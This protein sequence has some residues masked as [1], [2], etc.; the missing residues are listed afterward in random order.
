MKILHVADI[1]LGR[2]RLSGKLPDSDFAEALG[3]IVNIAISENVDV[4]LI[5]GDLFDS[6]QIH[7]PA[8]KQAITCLSPLKGEGIPVLAIEGN[9]DRVSLQ[10]ASPTWMRYL[11]DEG[12]LHLLTTPFAPDGPVLL[13]WD[14]GRRQG[15]WI[16]IN[17]IRFIGA[18]YLGAGTPKRVRAILEGIESGGPTVLV[19][20]AGPDYFVG[21]GG[22]FSKEDLSFIKDKVS[23]LALGHI[24][25]P[26]IHENWACNP[27]SPEN[28][29][30]QEDGKSYAL[31]NRGYA[32]VVICETARRPPESMEIRSNPRRPV[33][34][35]TL[36]CSPFGNKLKGG[37][38]A[39]RDS[40]VRALRQRG[41][42]P[43]SAVLLCLSGT[44]NI[45]RIG[46][47]PD[48]L[49]SE[50]EE[51]LGVKAVEVSTEKLQL[52]QGR[53]SS[54]LSGPELV[55]REELERSAILEILSEDPIGGL[56]EKAEELASL[57]M[58][59]KEHVR[60]EKPPEET[61]D[62]LAG[63][64]LTAELFN[65]RKGAL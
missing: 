24:H 15:S 14:T 28:C 56:E 63:H 36:D 43:D 45:G 40:A 54:A 26:M 61:A 9:H 27:G 6:P 22:G 13:P 44:L 50:L 5:A 17:G 3:H 64:H 34:I 8:L 55:T 47:D 30:L 37:L 49:A 4:F 10:S 31:H 2:E 38:E 35:E 46:L 33:I 20:H 7:P 25:K 1:H 21:E 23:Y 32:L 59:L 53:N 65:L 57:F 52:F 11:S 29:R 18:G 62:V 16:E 60:D 41:T 58:E 39:L 12:Y 48:M 19:L 42:T 51:K